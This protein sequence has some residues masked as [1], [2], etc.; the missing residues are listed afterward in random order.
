MDSQCPDMET[1]MEQSFG[2]A[3]SGTVLP[4]VCRCDEEVGV[5]SPSLA[6]RSISAAIIVL[7]LGTAPIASQAADLPALT[8]IGAKFETLGVQTGQTPEQVR[9]A[10]LKVDPNATVQEG[11]STD[12]ATSKSYVSQL[13]FASKQQN[14]ETPALVNATDTVGVLFSGPASGNR[15]IGVMREVNY[16]LAQGQPVRIDTI[17][18]FE[19]KYGRPPKYN[20]TAMFGNAPDPNNVRG[21][22]IF[23]KDGRIK[24]PDPKDNLAVCGIGTMT[25]LGSFSSGCV[26]THLC[27]SGITPVV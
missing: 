26:I 8:P 2:S 24:N 5:P 27:R 3:E 4:A 13:A 22:F 25:N 9:S 1:K 23:A 11:M 15:S 19:Q 14:S 17:S 10:L 21:T 16:V 20:S 6:S 12:Q 18:A 7:A